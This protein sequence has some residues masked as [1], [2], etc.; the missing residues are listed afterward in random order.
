MVDCNGSKSQWILH[1]CL[2]THA[3]IACFPECVTFMFRHIYCMCINKQQCSNHW[4][5]QLYDCVHPFTGMGNCM[6]HLRLPGC[7][8]AQEML[9]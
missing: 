5:L 3:C 2:P 6:R 9:Y 1:Q 7:G 4:R 8:K